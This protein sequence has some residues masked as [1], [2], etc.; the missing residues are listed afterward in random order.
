[1]GIAA[2]ISKVS[3]SELR[4]RGVFYS[5]IFAGL[6]S[7][8]KSVGF[9]FPP[10]FRGCE[11]QGEAEEENNVK[12]RRL[13]T[14]NQQIQEMFDPSTRSKESS[15]IEP[16]FREIELVLVAVLKCTSPREE[17]LLRLQ[18]W[19]SEKLVFDLEDVIPHHYRSLV[20]AVSSGL[21]GLEFSSGSTVDSPNAR[22][23]VSLSLSHF[24]KA[25]LSEDEVLLP[26][27]TNSLVFDVSNRFILIVEIPF[28]F[29]SYFCYFCFLIQ[30]LRL[31]PQFQVY[32]QLK[33]HLTY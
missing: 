27:Q 29:V 1:M 6:G 9:S 12:R 22:K 23:A 21:P 24:P 4:E 25:S 8:G 16:S 19:S 32:L 3:T 31:F 7:S 11:T 30:F 15:P 17:P 2:P 10:S 33:R 26:K 14:D 5:G 20:F 28:F 18:I 13:W